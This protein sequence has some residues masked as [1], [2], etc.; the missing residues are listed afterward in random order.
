MNAL[1]WHRLNEIGVAIK[2]M[3]RDNDIRVIIIKGTGR[4]FS[5]GYDIIPPTEEG[6]S[7]NFPPGGIYVNADRDWISG[8]YNRHHMAT[9]FLIWE[10]DK[11]VIAQIHGYCLAGATELASFC[12]LRLLAEGAQGR[13]PCST[14]HVHR[15]YPV[16]GMALGDDKS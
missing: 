11:P 5:A 9:Y 6:E 4:C 10:L 13:L 3:E 2:E 8:Q 7:R 16:D 15:Q 1:N 12:D 14:S